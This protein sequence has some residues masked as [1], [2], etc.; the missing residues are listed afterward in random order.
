M[1]IE[2]YLTTDEKI[3]A[4]AGSFYATNKRVIRYRKN[5]MGEELHDL[6]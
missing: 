6:A 2:R 1:T 5:I 4:T 3:L